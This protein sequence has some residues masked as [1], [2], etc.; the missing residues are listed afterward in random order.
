[1]L[2][3]PSS[4]TSGRRGLPEDGQLTLRSRRPSADQA[5]AR[6]GER[7]QSA[8]AES[9]EPEIG[10][11]GEPGGREHHEGGGEHHRMGKVRRPGAPGGDRSGP[12]RAHGRRSRRRGRPHAARCRSAREET[13]PLTITAA[14]SL[15]SARAPSTSGPLQH[16]VAG[17][18][19]VDQRVGSRR[20]P[21]GGPAR[22]RVSD[23]V[24]VHPRTATLP[25]RASIP[26][27]SALGRYVGRRPPA[28]SPARSPPRSPPRRGRGRGPAPAAPDRSVRNPPPAWIAAR[29]DTRWITRRTAASLSPVP[30]RA[31]QVHHVDP[32][33]ALQRRRRSATAAGSS[34]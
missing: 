11:C 5:T 21:R 19:G 23:E 33:R 9:L 10:E 26:T 34:P 15:C 4:S 24:S 1:M 3:E 7:H 20:P 29:P 28:G 32:A 13:P 18:V 8:A 22:R 27:A 16:A 30:E 2:S 31:V 14:P 12:R 6:G 17:D 25:S